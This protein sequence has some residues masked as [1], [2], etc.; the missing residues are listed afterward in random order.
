MADIFISYSRRDRESLE[1]LVLLFRTVY[2]NDSV[3]FDND[4]QGGDDWWARILL[5]IYKCKLFVFLVSDASL[6]S[7][8][9][10]KEVK[11]ALRLS[12]RVLPII[13]DTYTGNNILESLVKIDGM[14]PSIQLVNL[15]NGFDNALDMAK[16]WGAVNATGFGVTSSLS[17]IER[18]LLMHQYIILDKLY[19]DNGYSMAVQVMENGYE[20]HYDM[21]TQFLDDD[22]MSLEECREVIDI[23]AM[24]DFMDR[25][26][27]SHTSDPEIDEKVVKNIGFDGNYEGKQWGYLRFL[28]EEEERF[29]WLDYALRF[30]THFPVL[31]TY[32][33]MLVEYDKSSTPHQLTKDDMKR[34]ISA[35]NNPH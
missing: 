4:I 16:L 28:V 15:K 10:Q 7:E 5:E 12:R 21:I 9:C 25:Y 18:W 11:E 1:E 29:N 8:Y 33:R 34:I 14:L 6:E 3:W 27:K 22:T 35:R 17:K 19:P 13:L 20:L 2:G 26:I 30:N 24:F 32:R 23:L 31:E